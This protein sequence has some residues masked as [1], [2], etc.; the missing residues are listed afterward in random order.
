MTHLICSGC[1]RPASGFPRSIFHSATHKFWLIMTVAI[2]GAVSL[3]QS[4]DPSTQSSSPQSQPVQ[5]QQAPPAAATITL[6]AGTKLPL[7]LVRPLSVKHAKPGD[8]AYLQVTFPVTVGSQMVIPPGAYVQGVIDKIVKRDRYREL[9]E[10]EMKS[11]SLIF[12][13]GYT[14][15]ITGSVDVAPGI[16]EFRPPASGTPGPGQDVPAMSAVGT[17]PA[18]PPLPPLPS[19]GNGT[20]NAMIGLGVA[21][22]VGT[23]VAVVLANR[24]SDIEMAVGTPLVIVLSAPLELDRESV[25]AA[26]RQYSGQVASTQPPIVQPPVKPKMCHD[27][28]TPGTP[29]TVIPGSPGTPPTVI[30]GANGAPPTVIPG[31]PATPPTVIPGSPGTPPRDY[32]CK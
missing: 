11:A 24:G 27:P 30:P 12:S 5:Q 32:P 3:A 13:T 16:A 9:L 4:K 7:G 18:L 17:T 25:L 26:V 29:D 21:A 22:A 15:N 2:L 19:M 23:T 10:F 1:A 6:P 31:T 8:N 28:G 20:R 14:V